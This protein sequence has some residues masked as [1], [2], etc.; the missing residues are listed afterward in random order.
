MT[1]EIVLKHYRR[2]AMA[3]LKHLVRGEG[4]SYPMI[5]LE[6]G[7]LDIA[8]K[9]DSASSTLVETVRVAVEEATDHVFKF[10]G[11]SVILGEG[12]GTPTLRLTWRL[13]E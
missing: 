10:M 11:W 1:S 7:A 6:D 8:A 2:L 3:L 9:C 13:K 12:E 4:L 5:A